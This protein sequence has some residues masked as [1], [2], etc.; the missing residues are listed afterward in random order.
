MEHNTENP[1]KNVIAILPAR[2][3]S[4][5]L[6]GKMLLDLVGK[7]MIVR[8]M[9]RAREAALVDRVIVATDS[10]DIK[11]AVENAGGEAILTSPDHQSGS[12]RIAEVAQ[13]LPEG[14]I[15][16][17]VQGDEPLISPATIDRAVQAMLDDD[18]A[19]IVTTF[20]PID[21]AR[22]ALDPNVVKIVVGADDRAL[23]FSRSPIPFP[24]EAAI[25][26][27]HNIEKALSH[28]PGILALIKKHTGLYI[29]RREYLLEYAS[30]PP[31][32]LEKV[33]MLEQLRA[34]A[35]GG[36]IKAVAAVT[37][38]VGVDTPEQIAIVREIYS[39]EEDAEKLL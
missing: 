22:D 16:V 24:R 5:R 14:S 15:I 25:R 17:N 8:T 37:R 32:E 6:E 2:H 20:E 26:N 12:D 27:G 29:Y 35:N 33:E 4:T 28:E 19:D 30:M 31:N 21:D 3:G 7:P 23:Y 18:T 13:G 10:Q 34:L 1:P 9:E 38:S 39:A 36:V 11:N